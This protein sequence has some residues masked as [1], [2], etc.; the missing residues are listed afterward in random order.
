MAD[1]RTM[2]QLLEAPTE[3]YEDA[4]V[5]PEITANN[6]EIK[7]GLL[8]L[9]QNKQFLEMFKEDPPCYILLFQ[10]DPSTMKIFPSPE[11]RTKY[12]GFKLCFSPF[13]LEGLARNIAGKN[14]SSSSTPAISLIVADSKTMGSGFNFSTEE[15]H[16]LPPPQ[17]GMNVRTCKTKVKILQSQMANLTDMLSKFVTTNTASTSGSGT[18]PGP[19]AV[20][21]NTEV[22]KDTMP[23][24]NNGSTEDVQPPVVQIQSRI[25]ILDAQCFPVDTPIPKASIP[26]SIKEEDGPFSKRFGVV[27][28]E[29]DPST[30]NSREIKFEVHG[31]FQSYEATG[32][33]SLLW[34]VNEYRKTVLGFSD[35]VAYGNPY[36]CFEPIVLIHLPI[37]LHL[38][39]SALLLFEEANAF[40]ALD[41][42]KLSRKVDPTLL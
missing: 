32:L 12:V 25:H 23:P 22:T 9:V 2:A 26:I 10:Q 33:T 39:E 21:H 24:A 15:Q 42:S 6:F 18:L 37:N 8:N 4:I 14:P 30:S 11:K 28:F 19:K 5:I 40:L 36:P 34:L 20:S 17:W 29:P 35:S 41:G 13:S 27:E 31:K 3:G 38:G 16:Q 1:N 7:H